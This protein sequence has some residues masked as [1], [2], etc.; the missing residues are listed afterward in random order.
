V[1]DIVYLP[2]Q[3]EFDAIDAQADNFSD[4]ERSETFGAQFCGWV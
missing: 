3:R 1:E 4:T 2:V